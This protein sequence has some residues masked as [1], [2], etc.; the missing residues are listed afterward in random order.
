MHQSGHAV[1]AVVLGLGLKSVDIVPLR[2]PD[3]RKMDGLTALQISASAM[4]GKGE[5]ATFPHVVRCFAG[6][7]AEALIDPHVRNADRLQED[8]DEARRFAAAAVCGISRKRSGRME[9]TAR[10]QREKQVSST[11]WGMLPCP[12]PN[13]W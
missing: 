8:L 2:T 12:Q 13:R 9:V 3:G 11:R 7:L 6:G 1:S 5:A 4:D 10:A